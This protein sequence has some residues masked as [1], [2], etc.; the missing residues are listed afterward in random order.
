MTVFLGFHAFSGDLRRDAPHLEL[1]RA[2]PLSG[3][4]V[5]AGEIAAPFVTLAAEQGLLAALC[6]AFAAGAFPGSR[7]DHAAFALAMAI[8][9]PASSAAPFVIANGLVVLYP[10]WAGKPAG[11]A[12]PL[13]RLG[14]QNLVG[15][16]VAFAS[17]VAIAPA[18]LAGGVVAFATWPVLGTWAAPVGALAGAATIAI[19]AAVALRLLGRAFERIDASA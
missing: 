15:V 19:E 5:L 13:D 7:A 2:L 4:Q 9:G 10:D 12:S 14:A 1:L 11:G 6:Y 8:G 3:R 16:V 17:A 18:A